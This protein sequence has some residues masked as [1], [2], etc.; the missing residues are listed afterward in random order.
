[1]HYTGDWK[2]MDKHTVYI[3]WKT[4]NFE[5]TKQIHIP[6]LV[7]RM[8]TW[9][10]FWFREC[11]LEFL[12]FYI[13]KV[14]CKPKNTFIFVNS[15]QV[16]FLSFYFTFFYLCLLEN[17]V[18]LEIWFLTLVYVLLLFS[19][20]RNDYYT[21]C[22]NKHYTYATRISL[23]GLEGDHSFGV[24]SQF[25]LYLRNCTVLLALGG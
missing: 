4:R 14:S 9:K 20:Y 5:F 7:S 2:P 3:L 21:G 13:L 23:E 25:A 12:Y 8:E 11:K 16:I 18:F 17:P 22:S 1:M 19:R 24:L 10:F 6:I 15:Y